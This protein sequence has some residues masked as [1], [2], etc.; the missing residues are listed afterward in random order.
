MQR[1]SERK[2]L[3]ILS[4]AASIRD[5]NDIN[6]D[7]KAA[8]LTSFSFPRA[9]N[10]GVAV[11]LNSETHQLEQVAKIKQNNLAGRQA[12]SVF[13]EAHFPAQLDW[14]FASADLT[15]HFIILNFVATGRRQD[16]L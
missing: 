16:E 8:V 13:P 7:F 12:S 10:M 4:F 15:V 3:H 2:V 5:S 1:A 9:D 14:L 11:G 6:M